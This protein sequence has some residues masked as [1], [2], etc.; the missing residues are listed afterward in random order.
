MWSL[1]I[2]CTWFFVLSPFDP[3]LVSLSSYQSARVV[4]WN[5]LLSVPFRWFC[6]GWNSF[7]SFHR[8]R[9]MST[10][11]LLAARESGGAETPCGL[12]VLR[13]QPCS[14]SWQRFLR[15]SFDQFLENRACEV[16]LRRFAC[17]RLSAPPRESGRPRCLW[18]GFLSFPISENAKNEWTQCWKEKDWRRK[19]KKERKVVREQGRDRRGLLFWYSRNARKLTSAGYIEELSKTSDCG[20]TRTFVSTAKALKSIDELLN[21]FL[22][23][24]MRTSIDLCTCA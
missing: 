5:Y 9:I 10:R 21:R 17:L 22:T 18:L 4:V 19:R 23:F 6:S 12:H 15:R 24:W 13:G 2:F 20:N 8:I 16:L 3:F 1:C 14:E 7:G 11:A